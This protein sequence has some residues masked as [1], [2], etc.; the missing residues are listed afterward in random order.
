MLGLMVLFIQIMINIMKKVK[1]L[2]TIKKNALKKNI[3]IVGFQISFI[4]AQ[5]FA[6]VE[7]LYKSLKNNN[8]II[9]GFNQ[10]IKNPGYF[11]NLVVNSIIDVT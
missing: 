10:S 7:M 3:I 4:P 6:R 8:F 5:F 1:Y 2:I 9:Q 11:T